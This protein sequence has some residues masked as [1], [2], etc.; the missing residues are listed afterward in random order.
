M[1]D[2]VHLNVHTAY[3]LLDGACRID[4]LVK[5]AKE[6][7]QNAL[8]ITDNSALYG[9]I[10]FCDACAEHGIKPIIGCEVSIAEDSRRSPNRVYEPYRLTLL[11]E[12][13]TGYKNLC[14]LIT[15]QEPNGIDGGYVTDKECL[16][17][18]GGGLLA[19]SGA[20]NGEIGSLLSDNRTDDAL[21]AAEWYKKVFG[22]NFYLELSNHDTASEARLCTL[23]R[24]FSKRTGIPV[25]P[26][27]NVHYVEK[28]GSYAQRVLQCI[29]QNKRLSEPNS[30]ALPTE[31][32]YLKSAEEMSRFFTAEELALTGEIA[33]RCNVELEFGVAKLP[34]FTKDGVSDN[35][36]YFVRLCNKGAEKRYGTVTPEIR[37][38]L[39]YE[40]EIIKKMGFVD[41]FLIVWDFVRYAKTQ[42]IPVGPGRGSGAGSLCAY[43]MGITDIDPLRFNLLFERFLNP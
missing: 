16:E 7:G 20:E 37:K 18:Y 23:L 29:G 27:N 11:C 5:R 1:G 22:G 40:L 34:L 30:R 9:A 19:L 24:E 13:T 10:D 14:R 42:D 2:F 26:T 41:Y 32:Y 25:C 8:A 4:E 36:E 38:R 39:D 31:E 43:C 35:A 3:S 17:R 33:A 6:L 21:K 12:D 15:E 28:S